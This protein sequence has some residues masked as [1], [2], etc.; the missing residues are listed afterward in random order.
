MRNAGP[1]NSVRG[2][3]GGPRAGVER[4]AVFRSSKWEAFF[5]GLALALSLLVTTGCHL[6]WT[7]KI[8]IES[9]I[10]NDD[11]RLLNVEGTSNLPEESV[12]EA[13]LTD[14]N[15]RRW[16]SGRGQIRQ[17]RF[18]VILDISRCPGFHKLTLAVSFDPVV[19]SAKVQRLTG[20]RGEALGGPLV[21]DSHD[22]ALIVERKFMILEMTQREAAL[23]RLEQGDGDVKELESYLARHPED[24]E[25]LVGLGLAYLKQ[26]PSE[27]HPGSNAHKLLE[28]G[29]VQM[30]SRGSRLEIEARTWVARL[31]AE[32]EAAAV[33]RERLRNSDVKALLERE[34]LIVPG[35]ALGVIKMGMKM[36]F[37]MRHFPLDHSPDPNTQGLETFH[38]EGR[39]DLEIKVDRSA[40]AVVSASSDAVFF[41]LSNGLRVGS[42][43]DELRAHVPDINVHYGPATQGADGRMHARGTVELQGL[44]I[45]VERSYSP[46][47]PL[48]IELLARFEVIKEEVEAPSQPTPSV[49]STPSVKPAPSEDFTPAPEPDVEP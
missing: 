48:A 44:T 27:R 11:N 49:D 32:A 24:G 2:P 22:R 8:W 7:R 18:F 25:A 36:R 4:P 47:F 16:A 5:L 42:T 6:I 3:G 37:L 33:L 1:R 15:G 29:L 10:L 41:R 19:A 21:V 17:G 39:P 26:R 38:V 12:I 13:A 23:R 46:D 40:D 9:R 43:L 45:T 35:Q 20:P 31:K 34:N 14:K 30:G 28:R